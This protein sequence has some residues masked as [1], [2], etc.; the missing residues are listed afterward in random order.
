L[1]KWASG[2]ISPGADII[3]RLAKV[4]VSTP[5]ALALVN[6]ATIDELTADDIDILTKRG[7]AIKD[8]SL[9]ADAAFPDPPAAAPAPTQAEEGR[10]MKLG[11]KADP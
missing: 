9:T 7:K 1:A 10:K 3:S 8:K 11:G 2:T 5:R 4:G 6:R